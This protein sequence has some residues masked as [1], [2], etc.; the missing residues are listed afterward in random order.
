M[1]DQTKAPTKLTRKQ[2]DFADY[3]ISNPKE[4]ATNAVMQAYAV[5]SREV[6]KSMASENLAKPNIVLYLDEHVDKAKRKIVDLV[7][8][9]KEDIALRASTDILDRTHGKATQQVEHKVQ[10]ININIDL[11]AIESQELE[12]TPAPPSTLGR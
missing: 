2:K 7:G 9:D 10:S 8:S 5:K 3:L 1:N 12:E 6:A 11:T 4:P